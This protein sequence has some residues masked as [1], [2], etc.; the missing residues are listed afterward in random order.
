M[1]RRVVLFAIPIVVV[2]VLGLTSGLASLAYAQA[3]TDTPSPTT[4][5][6]PTRTPTATPILID[7]LEPNDTP[8]Q[9]AIM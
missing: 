5:P 4:T 8:A 7:E 2:G 9:G 3:N 6:S 1:N